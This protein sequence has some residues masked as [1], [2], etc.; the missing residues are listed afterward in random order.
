MDRLNMNTSVYTS[1]LSEPFDPAT[2]DDKTSPNSVLGLSASTSTCTDFPETFSIVDSK[3]N[4]SSFS[5][6][7]VELKATPHNPSTSHKLN[8]LT[9]EHLIIGTIDSG[10]TMVPLDLQRLDTHEGVKVDGLLDCGAS[11]EF[12]DKEFA[13]GN[14]LPI[15]RLPRAIP[16]YNVDRTK[17]INGS[18]TECMWLLMRYKNHHKKVQF[19]LTNTSKSSV[20]LGHTWLKKHNPEI[21]WRMGE[22]KMTHCPS[23][24]G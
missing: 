6:M 17:N 11:G 7:H 24:C 10:S 22:V 3:P 19:Y 1:S 4:S 21:D 2:I 15:E 12:M 5:Y 8:F 9:D 18:T 16:I 14:N 20:I 13:L 23:S